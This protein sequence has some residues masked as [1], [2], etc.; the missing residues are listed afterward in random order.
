[1]ENFCIG[2]ELERIWNGSAAAAGYRKGIILLMESSCR[3]IYICREECGHD[4]AYGE[5][6]KIGEQAYKLI[7]RRSV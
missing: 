6:G 7:K 2:E 4:H 5:E 1:M 3:H